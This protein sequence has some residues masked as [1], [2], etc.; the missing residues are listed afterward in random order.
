MTLSGMRRWSRM[1]AIILLLAAAGGLPHLVQDDSA[2]L[3]SSPQGYGPH[4]E[5]QHGM[6]AAGA[7]ADRDHCALCHWT[8][9]LRSPLARLGPAAVQLALP[10]SIYRPPTAAPLAPILDN[11]P[12][13]A[14]PSRA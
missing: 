9:S 14:P 1:V 11:L 13:R 10:S 3:A 8:R 7:A 4:D 2:C 5:S 6:R 12:S